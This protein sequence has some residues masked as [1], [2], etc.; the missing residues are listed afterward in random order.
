VKVLNV[1]NSGTYTRGL[2]LRK[3]GEKRPPNICLFTYVYSF[4]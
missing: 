2:V 1:C 4:I 3:A